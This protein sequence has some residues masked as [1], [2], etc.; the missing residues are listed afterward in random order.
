MERVFYTAIFEKVDGQFQISFPNKEL[1]TVEEDTLEKALNSAREVIALAVMDAEAEGKEFL[2]Q[3][4][5]QENLQKGQSLISIDLWM[6]LERAKV[7]ETYTKKTLTI[8]LWLDLLAKKKNI[9]FSQVLTKGLKK[10]LL[11]KK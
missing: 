1:L 4:I 5:N 2:I 3:Q 11:I 8:P 10:E 9:N 6:P 7:K